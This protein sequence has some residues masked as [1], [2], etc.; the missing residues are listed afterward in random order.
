VIPVGYNRRV[1]IA[2]RGDSVATDSGYG[3]AG[4]FTN[5][6]TNV[7]CNIEHNTGAKALVYDG[8]RFVATGVAYFP[9]NLDIRTGD[10][11]LI[12]TEKYEIVRSHLVFAGVNIPR[13]RHCEW[14]AVQT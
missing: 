2:R 12:G 14:R 8:Q 13:Y 4:V 9:T 10:R 5:Q 6:F 1:T 11:I 7:P 3:N